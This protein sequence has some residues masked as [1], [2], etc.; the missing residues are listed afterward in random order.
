MRVRKKKNLNKVDTNNTLEDL[1]PDIF[2]F[3]QVHTA[4]IV[5][6]EANK[7]IYQSL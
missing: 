2:V 5:T 1:L 6:N 3:R 7:C 4:V